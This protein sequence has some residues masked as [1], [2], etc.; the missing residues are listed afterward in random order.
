MGGENAGA[1]ALAVALFVIG[2]L[3]IV[4]AV[5]G[6]YREVWAAL[7]TPRG[8]DEPGGNEGGDEP[9]IPPE[10]QPPGRP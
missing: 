3:L 9:P 2:G 4:G 10:K 5:R 6:T 7:I 1:A 8:G